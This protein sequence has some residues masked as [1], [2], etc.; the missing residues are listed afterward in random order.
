MD[1]PLEEVPLTKTRLK[2]MQMYIYLCDW[3]P[4]MWADIFEVIPIV[5]TNIGAY[6]DIPIWE[7]LVDTP[8]LKKEYP[9]FYEKIKDKHKHGTY[10]IYGALYSQRTYDTFSRLLA[11]ENVPIPQ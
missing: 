6:A 2:M 7:D 4:Q 5:R 10:M 11:R 1:L 9:G 8:T 3:G